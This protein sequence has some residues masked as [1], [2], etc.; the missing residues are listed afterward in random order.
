MLASWDSNVDRGCGNNL[1]V[2]KGKARLVDALIAAAISIDTTVAL[3]PQSS[4]DDG[5][6]AGRK[7]PGL[8]PK[9]WIYSNRAAGQVSAR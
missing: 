7:I 9:L 5:P 4:L 6:Q 2:G 8:T 1:W 3:G